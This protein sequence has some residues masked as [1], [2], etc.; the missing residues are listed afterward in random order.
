MLKIRHTGKE[1]LDL[2]TKETLTV[3]SSYFLNKSKVEIAIGKNLY[4]IFYWRNAEQFNFFSPAI[5]E[6]LDF[7]S[8]DKLWN[9]FSRQK[10]CVFLQGNEGRVTTAWTDLMEND[11]EALR[12]RVG[13]LGKGATRRSYFLVF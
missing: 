11:K 13:D 2:V 3:D 12:D 9:I 7:F 6:Q 1:Q 5:N 8:F 10:N 4:L